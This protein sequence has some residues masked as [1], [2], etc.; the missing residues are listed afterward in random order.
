ML[1]TWKVFIQRQNILCPFL[2]S[3][4]FFQIFNWNI[5]QQS[6]SIN[7]MSYGTNSNLL[8]CK[9]AG[10]LYGLRLL[11]QTEEGCGMPR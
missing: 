1:G 6:F 8:G 5:I 2:F 3:E 4:V 10:N 11:G 7:R 9:I